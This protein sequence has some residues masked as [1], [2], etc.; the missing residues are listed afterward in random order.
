MLG[1]LVRKSRQDTGKN[2]CPDQTSYPHELEMGCSLAI[3]L[4]GD[5][6]RSRAQDVLRKVGVKTSQHGPITSFHKSQDYFAAL[7]K[8]QTFLDSGCGDTDSELPGDAFLS[9]M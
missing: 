3:H 9:Q 1:E 8:Q 4:S 7:S 2:G 6:P 5:F